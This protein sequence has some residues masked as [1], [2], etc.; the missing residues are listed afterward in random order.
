MAL[1]CLGNGSNWI[2]Y[3]MY[4]GGTNPTGP[5]GFAN[6]RLHPL[7]SYDFQAPLVADGEVR[8]SYRYLKLLHLFAHAFGER[9][10]PMQ[11]VLP[12]DVSMLQPDTADVLRWC[13]R[14]RAGVGLPLCQ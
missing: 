2:G 13:V 3:Y 4:H 11:T 5:Y 6:E 7:L 14:A 9:L 12:D 8:A 10:A 1:V